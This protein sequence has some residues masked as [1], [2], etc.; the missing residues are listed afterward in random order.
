MQFSIP[1]APTK[2]T[3][4]TTFVLD[5]TTHLRLTPIEL[6]HCKLFNSRRT[7]FSGV[8]LLITDNVRVDPSAMACN[9]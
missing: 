8:T 2:T 1:T 5:L 6:I 4:F 9:F 7:N 3:Q